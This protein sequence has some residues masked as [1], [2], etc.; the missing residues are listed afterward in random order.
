MAARIAIIVEGE[1]ETLLK[2][3]LD[4]Y[5]KRFLAGRMPRLD[6]VPQ[7]GRLPTGD[8]LKRLVCR[9][10]KTHDAVIALTDVYTGANPPAFTDAADAK[11]KLSAWV[12][13]EPRFH[14]HAAQY[15][16]EAWLLPFWPRIVDLAGS[17]RRAPSGPPEQVN[18][19]RPPAR[20]LNE[21]FQTGSRGRRYSKTRD[22]AAILRDQDIEHAA[23]ACPELRALLDTLARLAAGTG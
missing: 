6:F 3:A 2:P 21:V 22:G 16:T 7:G 23:N 11:A 8:G 19:D 17:R 10:L 18:H 5:L 14:P 20:L 12:G 4:R 13:D 15:E 9:L 1:T